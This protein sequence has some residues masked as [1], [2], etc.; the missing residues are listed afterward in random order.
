MILATLAQRRGDARALMQRRD[1]DGGDADECEARAPTI[2]SL[3]DLRGP[4]NF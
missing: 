1:G 4:G 3:A 2:V